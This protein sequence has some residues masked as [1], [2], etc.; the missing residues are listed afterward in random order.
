MLTPMLVGVSFLLVLLT[1]SLVAEIIRQA[2]ITSRS[3]LVQ[4]AER[5]RSCIADEEPSFG[6]RGGSF[7]VE[8]TTP[9]IKS[10]PLPSETAGKK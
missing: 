3:R 8:K 4:F 9:Y 2:G 7:V 1:Y 5:I 6:I 10:S